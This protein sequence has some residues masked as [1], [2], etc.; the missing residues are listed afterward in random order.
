MSRAKLES[1]VKYKKSTKRNNNEN[2]KN[3]ELYYMINMKLCFG[4]IYIYI[5]FK[6]KS[7]IQFA[8]GLQRY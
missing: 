4:Y 1:I 6:N 2:Y 3:K 8:T 7:T 5:T